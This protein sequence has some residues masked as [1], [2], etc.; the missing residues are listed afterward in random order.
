MKI[1]FVD[2][3]AQYLPIKSEIDS[4]IQNVIDKTAFTL[5]EEVEIFEKNF[6]DYCGSKYCIGISS[7]TDAL[8]LALRAIGVGYGDE[9][10]VPVNS[11]IATAEAV[12]HC[13]AIPVFVDVD[14][15]TYNLDV[16]KIEEKITVKTKAII[17]VHLYGQLADMD[18]VIGIAGRYNLKVVEDACQAHGAEALN[19]E[20]AWQ[21]AGTFGDAACFSFYPGK[22]LGAY[23][24][25]GAVVTNDSVIAEKLRLLRSHGENAKYI[26][27]VVGY[28]N[29][30]HAIQAA[31]LN[32]KLNKLD[33]WNRKRKNNAQLYGK[34]LSGSGV[35]VPYCGENRRHV[36]HLYVIRAEDRDGLID[37]LSDRGVSTGI[38]Y[39][40]PIHLQGAYN[41]SGYREGNFPVAEKISKEILSLPMFPELTSEQIEYITELIRKKFKD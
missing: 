24:D 28:C 35:T 5:G 27:S 3:K 32:V 7:G 13:G 25:G 12:S 30:L 39:P 19:K 10:I 36:Y 38:H 37:F 21:R 17:P 14:E 23:G 41:N 4:A 31:I 20:G 16:L 29:R 22:N 8:H 6:A 11:F 40:T 15:K 1:N 34:L 18:A 9:V 2:L 26:H 33:E